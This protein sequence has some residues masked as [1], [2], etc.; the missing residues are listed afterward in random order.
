MLRVVDLGHTAIVTDN[1]VV[2]GMARIVLGPCVTTPGSPIDSH[3]PPA[4]SEKPAAYN[5]PI[6]LRKP[7]WS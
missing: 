1:D 3:Q 4:T 7:T 2:Y 6:C 5:T